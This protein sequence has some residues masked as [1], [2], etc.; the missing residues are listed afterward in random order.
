LG[1]TTKYAASNAEL[2]SVSNVVT[3]ALAHNLNT[4]DVSVQIRDLGTN[5]E[6]FVD[7]AITNA[8]TVTLSW[9]ASA[10]VAADSYR[11]VVVG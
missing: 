8:N 6:V 10:N 5:A 2:E 4:S 7:V 3:W 1:A 9:N 11:A